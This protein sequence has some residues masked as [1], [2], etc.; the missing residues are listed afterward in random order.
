MSVALP[1]VLV[2]AA[3][4]A[5]VVG[6]LHFLARR[7]PTPWLLPT[8]RFLPLGDAPATSVRRALDDRLLLLLRLLAIGSLALGA[9][10]I[11]C[12]G[13]G[14][15]TR[16]VLVV[17]SALASD[18]ARWMAAI[19]EE[20]H[21]VP[22][23]V[24]RLVTA[25][26]AEWPSL[27]FVDALQ[28]AAQVASDAPAVRQVALH[29]VLPDSVRADDAWS[30]WR[31]QWPARID[32]QVAPQRTGNAGP[33]EA[34]SP[35]P[36][37]L[38]RWPAPSGAPA[39]LRGFSPRR[40]VDTVGALIA[41]GSPI[42][43]PW[44]RRWEAVSWARAST[45]DRGHPIA[46]WSDGEP[47]VMEFSTPTGCE[48]TVAVEAPAGSDLLI[49]S[50]AVGWRRVLAA[51]CGTAADGARLAAHLLVADSMPRGARWPRFLSVD[52]LRDGRMEPLEPAPRWLGPACL[53]VALLL[54]GV[55][56][57]WRS[58]ERP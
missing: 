9:A 31:A 54:L 4:G 56:A 17:D 26:L 6:L 30:G 48:R 7:T 29:V 40:V 15:S 41:G 21:A 45:P 44:R 18:S 34:T 13:G 51:P 3:V 5:V 10:G 42:V 46:W 53:T 1:W 37:P 32:V 36:A 33:P 19:A 14:A 58:R 22:R 11:R 52:W 38:V 24:I 8:I 12:G 49:S 55:E 2:A 35:M 57:W 47:A 23:S 43:A 16:H 20:G 27:A 39:A 50:A 28:V 25:P